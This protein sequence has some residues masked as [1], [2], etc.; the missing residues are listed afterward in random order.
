M[1]TL[2]DFKDTWL[3]PEGLCGEVEE[4]STR[5]EILE[6]MNEFYIVEKGGADKK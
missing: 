2:D 6:Y 1:V 5:C 4:A 3:E